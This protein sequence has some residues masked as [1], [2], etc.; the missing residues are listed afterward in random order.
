MGQKVNPVGM[1]IGV[2]KDWNSRWFA[3]D[4]EYPVYLNEDVKI[5]KYLASSLKE[6]LLSHVEIERTKTDKGTNVVVKTFVARP[7]VVIGQDGKNIL[8][9]KEALA[10]LIKNKSV[11]VDVVEV[12]NPDLDATIVA[13]TIAK[14]L[15]ERASFR[16]V[17]KKAIQRVRKAGAKGCRTMVSGRL[18][19]A[20]IARSEGYK[21][22][23]IPL[24]TLR[25]DI[26]YAVSEAATQ[27]GRL[28]VKVW[29]CRGEIRPELKK[30]EKGE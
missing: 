28:G 5:R 12:K 29:I 25:S 3:E 1:R 13:Q 4:K 15:E 22:G 17:Q 16:T 6:A 21:E 18:G 24:H 10:K 9:L 14:Q 8:A 19:G 7:G 30:S 2:N 26:D 11:R 27:Y 20:D 23:V